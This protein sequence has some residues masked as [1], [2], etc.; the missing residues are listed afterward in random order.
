MNIGVSLSYMGFLLGQTIIIGEA[1]GQSPS[2]IKSFTIQAS[3]KMALSLI[4]LPVFI[5]G[6]T[7]VFRIQ[8]GPHET[9]EDGGPLAHLGRGISEG[10]LFLSACYLT[11]AI[12]ENI[13]FGSF[14]P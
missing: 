10:G 9:D 2:D 1:V 13:H 3:L 14:Y 8:N 4:I 6:L 5:R 12:T 11:K 7:L